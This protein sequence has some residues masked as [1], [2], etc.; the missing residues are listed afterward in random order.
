M[1][2]GEQ[3]HHLEELLKQKQELREQQLIE[4]K[5]SEAET[6]SIEIAKLQEKLKSKQLDHLILSQNNERELFERQFEEEKNS[7]N[8]TW[9]TLF[10]SYNSKCENEI[11]EFNKKRKEDVLAEKKR[12]ESTLHM[13][14]KPSSALLN[15]TRCKEKAIKAGKY[16]DAQILHNQIEEAK[17]FEESKFADQK[18][19]AVDQGILNFQQVYEKKLQNLKKRHHAGFNELEIQRAGEFN[20]VVKKYENLKRDMENNHEI[21]R[22]IHMGKHTT[23]AGRHHQSPNKGMYSTSSSLNPMSSVRRAEDDS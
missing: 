15:M 22:N 4:N 14:F 5:Y 11:Q 2:T 8:K 18:R 6:S 17:A 10:D 19:A 13:F 20:V 9:D 21:R 23:A 12:L 3:L 7:L 16:A 1:A